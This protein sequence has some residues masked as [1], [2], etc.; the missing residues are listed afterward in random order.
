MIIVVTTIGPRKTFS[1]LYQ[2]LPCEIRS[3][4]WKPLPP[5]TAM[6]AVAAMIRIKRMMLLIASLSST[7]KEY[8][9]HLWDK[10][11]PQGNITLNLL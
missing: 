10:L 11:I 4:C 9:L 8:P 7:D 3:H 1:H 5:L 2:H 6:A